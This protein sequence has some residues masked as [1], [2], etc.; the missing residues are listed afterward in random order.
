[1]KM[2]RKCKRESVGSVFEDFGIPRKRLR[3]EYLDQASSKEINI[4][5]LP[6]KQTVV[7]EVQDKQ[8]ETPGKPANTPLSSLRRSMTN[9]QMHCVWNSDQKNLMADPI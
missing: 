2:E 8:A 7:E 9:K 5:D 6:I 4:E 3:V 1:M